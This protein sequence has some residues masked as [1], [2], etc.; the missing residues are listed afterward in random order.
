MSR[1]AAVP[2]APDDEAALLGAALLTREA[3]E[4][5][6]NHTS[7]SDFYLPFHRRLRD[8][9]VDHVAAGQPV[10]PVTITSTLAKLNGAAGPPA[11]K[12]QLLALQAE[13]PNAANAPAYLRAVR[14]CE[15][16][17]RMLTIA[18]QLTDAATVDGPVDGVVAQLE[19]LHFE[20]RIG[21]STWDQADVGAVTA[22]LT[23][24]VV[25]LEP[26]VL[27]R[28]D[29]TCLLYAGKIHTFAGEPESGKTWLL[30]HAC[31]EQIDA[32]RHAFYL[33]FEDDLTSVIARLVALGVDG[34]RIVDQ[35]HYMRPTEPLGRA[36]WA[37][38]AG[39]LA[40]YQPTV[41]VIDGLTE[42]L[43]LH[44]LEVNSNRDNAAFFALLPRPIAHLGPAVG[45]IDHVAKDSDQRGRWSIGAQHKLAGVD[46][47]AYGLEVIKPIVRGRE[48][49]VKVTVRKDRPGHV[50]RASAG[51]VVA[52]LRTHS[53][54]A[55]MEIEL[56][57]GDHGGGDSDTPFRPTVLMESVSRWLELNPD[58]PKKSIKTSVRGRPQYV[59]GALDILIA[60]GNIAVTAGPRGALLCRVV[61][62][63]RNDD[64][65]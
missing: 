25:D 3:A 49:L 50:R 16:R 6:A 23:G 33:D 1:V 54:G 20:Q 13:C 35:F 47:A 31:A 21:R 65:A 28:S 15:R 40:T 56:A 39:L 51:K 27:V 64:A 38:Y 7:S 9:I 36:D 52:E 22:A 24:D 30:L 57:A 42:A 29:G 60:E 26:T 44:G 43:T 10:D 32:G 61:N 18:G 41:V 4:L 63:Y 12:A 58:S 5:V 55:V 2:T 17:R 48:G 45:I 62:P 19:G 14:G 59:A 37:I 34:Q 8:A 46:G 11:T 53:V